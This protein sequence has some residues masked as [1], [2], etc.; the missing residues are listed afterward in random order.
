MTLRDTELIGK[1]LVK[2]GF[3]R[4]NTNPHVY[5]NSALPYHNGR[6]IELGYGRGIELCFRLSGSVWVVSFIHHIDFHTTVKFDGHQALFT[7]EWLV[8]EHKKLQAMFKF[9]RG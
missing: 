7:P 1:K 3:Y 6:G 2:Y 8:E 5:K 4:S 9:I